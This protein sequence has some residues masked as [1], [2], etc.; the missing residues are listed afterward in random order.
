MI[1][2]EVLPL[3]KPTGFKRDINIDSCQLD[4]THIQARGQLTDTRTDFEDPDKT[5][6]V[7]CLIVLLTIRS[8]DSTIIAAE[9]GTPKM[10]FEDMCEHLPYGAEKLV[11]EN[12]SKGFS[13]RLRE[14]YGGKRSCFHLSSLLQAMVPALPQCRSWNHDFKLMDELLP[15]ESVPVAMG[16]M[17]G[18][19]KNSCH[20]WEEKDGGISVDFRD[21]NYDPML[22][23]MA[24]RLLGR[25]KQ[26]EVPEESQEESQEE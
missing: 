6:I 7:H 8:S 23:R 14:L 16:A 20:A 11:G 25:W 19:A 1:Y 15:A 10:A 12:V 24:P 4:D 22:N 3:E 13:F 2:E 5:I 26:H 21:K 9:F 17:L 18:G